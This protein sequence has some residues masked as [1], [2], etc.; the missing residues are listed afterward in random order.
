MVSHTQPQCGFAPLRNNICTIFMSP[1]RRAA[2]SLA[3]ADAG[4]GRTPR[5]RSRFRRRELVHARHIR[6]SPSVV[7]AESLNA[8]VDNLFVQTGQA[9]L[10]TMSRAT[11]RR[12]IKVGSRGR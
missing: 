6:A 8:A 2:A 10:A 12:L 4:L 9:F 1:C 7:R 5:E 3:A 11:I